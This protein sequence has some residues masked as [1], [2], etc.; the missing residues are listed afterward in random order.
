[1]AVIEVSE[2][3]RVHMLLVSVAVFGAPLV[4][5]TI[6]IYHSA[7]WSCRFSLSLN[8]PRGRRS[9]WL[10]TG[11]ARD[12]GAERVCGTQREFVSFSIILMLCELLRLTSACHALTPAW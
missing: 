11:I 10:L 8:K 1:M 6:M 4:S 7:W 12:I 3:A 5:T 2:T 9:R